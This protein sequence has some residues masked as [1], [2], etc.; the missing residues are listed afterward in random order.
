M[1]C[2][3]QKFVLVN[4][5]LVKSRLTLGDSFVL[6][7]DCELGDQFQVGLDYKSLPQEVLAGN[8]LLLDD[9]RITMSVERVKGNQIHCVVLQVEHYQTTKASICKAVDLQ[10]MR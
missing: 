1:I 5:S 10:R 9:G 4:L 2:K 7:A 3:A 8:V 6:N